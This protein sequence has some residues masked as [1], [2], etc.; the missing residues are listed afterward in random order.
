MGWIDRN[1][2]LLTG[3]EHA[4]RAIA[5][6]ERDPWGHIALGYWALMERRTE[7]SIA[8]FRRALNLNPNL[9]AAHAHLSHIFAFAGRIGRQSSTPKTRSGSVRWTLRWHSSSVVLRLRIIQPG[10]LRKPPSM[11]QKPYGGAPVFRGRNVCAAQAWPSWDA[12]RKRD[13]FWRRPT[14]AAPLSI[15]WIRASVPYQTPQL[16]E[17]FLEGMRKAGLEE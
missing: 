3:R 10:D 13:A 2:G 16:M 7:K 15:S 14:R 8:A 6:D 4:V 12:S 17:R 9:A 5:L 11:R 1:K